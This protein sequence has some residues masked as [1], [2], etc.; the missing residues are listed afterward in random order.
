MKHTKKEDVAFNQT[1]ILGC[2]GPVIFG[3][4]RLFSKF[5]SDSNI[6]VIIIFLKI[7]AYLRLKLPFIKKLYTRKGVKPRS[8]KKDSRGFNLFYLAGGA[9]LMAL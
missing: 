1:S 3:R 4:I 8:C 2:A 9:L 5:L 7:I 6:P